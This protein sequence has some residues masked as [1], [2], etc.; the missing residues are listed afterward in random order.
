MII[1]YRFG[2]DFLIAIT[3]W[4]LVILILLPHFKRHADKSR[5][6]YSQEHQVNKTLFSLISQLSFPNDICLIRYGSYII[7]SVHRQ[8]IRPILLFLKIT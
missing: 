5:E 4:I 8:K 1:R 3:I 2:L 6:I 7:L